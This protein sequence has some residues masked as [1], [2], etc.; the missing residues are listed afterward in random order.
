M[1]FANGRPAIVAELS[2]N[3]EGSLERCMRLM[4]LAHENGADAVKIQTYTED[5]LT[6]DSD[7]PEFRI[8][9]GL[10]KG[11]TLYELY[12]KAKTPREWM[13]PLFRHASENGIRLFST[14]FSLE[15]LKALEDAGCPCYKVASFELNYVQLVSACAKTGKPMVMSTG[16]ATQDEIDRAVEAAENGGCTDLTLLVCQ[17]SYPADPAKFSLRTIPYL[18]D[19][20][21]CKAGLSDHALGDV[22]D[23]AATALGADMIEKHFTD[24]RARG[25]VDSAFSMEP[26]DLRKL[27][28]D[29]SEA[30]ASLGEYGVRLTGEEKAS[31][32]GRRSVYL[33]KP[34]KKGSI[35]T[36]DCVRIVRPA[37]GME[38]YL[39]DEV[40]GKKANRDLEA[41]VPL[42]REFFD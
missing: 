6:L 7:R 12:K 35:L 1:D 41:P 4:D 8:N 29:T 30:A 17:S 5:S 27:V 11:Q 20:Y 25:S 23:I 21:G 9:G 33:V 34:L 26:C 22:Q 3:H 37:Y 24:D 19:R 38:P 32:G 28:A 16:L 42:E 15:D 36:E 14:P 31:R 40:L 10:W 18:K 2:G 13:K 39:L